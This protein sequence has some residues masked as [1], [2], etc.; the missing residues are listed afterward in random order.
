MK[1]LIVSESKLK[2]VMEKE[3]SEKYGIDYSAVNSSKNRRAF[4]EI[5]A[6]A[7][8]EVGFDVSD[9]K[10]L[11]QFYPTADGGCEVF[12]TKLGVLSGGAAEAI[13]RSHKVAVLSKNYDYYYVGDLDRLISL[14]KAIS[15]VRIPKSDVYKTDDGLYYIA[16]ESHNS[17]S[18]VGEFPFISEFASKVKKDFGSYIREHYERISEKNAVE[19]FSL[20]TV[21]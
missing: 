1:F 7:K 16:I 17:S 18:S 6:V 9:D 15:M 20:M 21:K 8:S 14:C 3:D 10:A 11:I 19:H 2:I 12:V 5:L 4:F 13:N